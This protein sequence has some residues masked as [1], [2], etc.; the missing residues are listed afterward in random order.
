MKDNFKILASDLDGTIF[1]E[2][3]I[4]EDDLKAIKKLRENGHKF[5]ISTG[6]TLTGIKKVLDIYD[7]EFDY[8]VLCN[9]GII[10]ND[11]FEEIHNNK[12]DFELGKSVIEDFNS[13]CF[14]PCAQFISRIILH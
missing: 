11:K 2:H 7:I 9:G 14:I 1:V 3:K 13:F 10:L 8:L 6:R 4:H 12:I 5:I